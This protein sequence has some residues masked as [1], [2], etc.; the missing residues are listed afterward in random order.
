MGDCETFI[1]KIR[2][3]VKVASFRLWF[4]K[5]ESNNELYA[6]MVTDVAFKGVECVLYRDVRFEKEQAKIG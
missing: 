1:K 3:V 2:E 5:K 4:Y 6:V